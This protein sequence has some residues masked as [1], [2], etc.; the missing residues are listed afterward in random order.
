M[1]LPVIGASVRHRRT[2][3]GIDTP[4]HYTT[5]PARL[6]CRPGGAAIVAGTLRVPSANSPGTRSVP[7]TNER[8]RGGFTLV[9]L[10][11]VMLVLAILIGLLLPA[12]RGSAD[13]GQT[14]RS[15]GVS[16]GPSSSK[17]IGGKP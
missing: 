3:G 13:G 10:L 15:R 17:A 9:E 14:H 2:R 5:A 4:Y 16:S 11:V 6:A 7:A 12:R 8:P 1:R